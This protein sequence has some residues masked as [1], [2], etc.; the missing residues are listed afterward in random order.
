[1]PT[2]IKK[3]PF[4]RE[5]QG[6]IQKDTSQEGVR[7]SPKTVTREPLIALPKYKAEMGNAERERQAP[8]APPL[9]GISA[10]QLFGGDIGITYRDYL[11]LPGYIDFP[12]R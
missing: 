8:L 7:P 5:I 4:P 12:A 11:A 6:E 3:Q 9:D 1:M 10:E 2:L